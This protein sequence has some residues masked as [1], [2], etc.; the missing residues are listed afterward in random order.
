MIDNS[1]SIPS[2]NTWLKVRQGEEYINSRVETVYH[3]FSEALFRH[4]I[5]GRDWGKMGGF[6]KH[7]YCAVWLKGVTGFIVWYTE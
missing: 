7:Y 2:S 4:S 6:R 5:M 3:T 1:I